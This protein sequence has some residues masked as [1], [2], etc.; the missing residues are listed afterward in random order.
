[1]QLLDKWRNYKE[2]R[3]ET[4]YADELSEDEIVHPNELK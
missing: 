4:L 2:T 3:K 1:M